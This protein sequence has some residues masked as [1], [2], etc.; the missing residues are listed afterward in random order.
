MQNN[1]AI[2]QTSRWVSVSA[3]FSIAVGLSV[4]GGTNADP[5][6]VGIG[7]GIMFGNAIALIVWRCLHDRPEANERI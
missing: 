2:H 5:R 4:I 6:G 3:L 1:P 7:C